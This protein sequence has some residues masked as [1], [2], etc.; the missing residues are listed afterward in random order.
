MRILALLLTLFGIAASQ[1]LLLPERPLSA[2]TGSALYNAL[3]PLNRAARE[4]TIYKEIV[5]G[6]VPGFLRTLVPVSTSKL[7]NG[8]TY[9]LRYFVTP[10]YLA[11]GHDSDYVLM[12]MTPILAQR[13][14]NY[15]HCTLPTARMVDQIYST[16]S[17]K[18]RPQPIPPDANMDKIPRFYQHHDSVRALRTPL[19]GTHPLGSLVGGTKKDVIIDKRVYSWIRG[20]V[21]KP[22]VIYGWHQLNGSPI[23]P[24]YN[25]HAETYADYSHG[26]RLIS[27]MAKINDADVSLIDLLQDPV[28][29]SMLCDTVLVKPY[30]GSLTGVDR[31]NEIVPRRHELK[32]N[33]P[34]PFNPSTRIEFNLSAEESVTLK[35]FDSLGREIVTLIDARLNTGSYSLQFENSGSSISSGAYYYRL[36]SPTFSHTKRMVILQ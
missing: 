35:V 18:L 32:Q 4:D 29:Y 33:Y 1:Q 20:A 26:I 14:A 8:T 16:A 9:V 5:S 11:V 19:L 12:P 17:V 2:R 28:F 7:I 3:V 25:G 23:Q 21:P 24:A 34:N 27:R 30:Y 31:I 13:I 10:D 22:V 36:Q 6:N 15:L